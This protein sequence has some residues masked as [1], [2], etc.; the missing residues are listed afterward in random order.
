MVSVDPS[1]VIGRQ[2]SCGNDAMDVMMGRQFCPQVCR[3]AKKPISAPRCSGS[4]A[5]SNK[6]SA[7]STE[8]TG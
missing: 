8:T 7:T 6:V 2:C 4:A 5:T 1:P 3:I